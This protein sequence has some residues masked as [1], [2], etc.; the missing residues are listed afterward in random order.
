[1][2]DNWF[3]NFKPFDVPMIRDRI[4]YPTP[5]HYFQAMKT[6]DL[7]I[8]QKIAALP[9]ARQAKRAGRRAPLRADWEE[10]KVEIMTQAQY[11]RYRRGTAMLERLLA[12]EGEI[13]EWNTW[14]DCTWGKCTCDRC[15]GEG[16]N[17]LGKILM[18]LRDEY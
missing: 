14:H 15:R 16:E 5:E 6:T 4:A 3:S 9:T 12:T 18:R 7:A 13:V 2:A 10:V 8:R 17:L 11:H 1:M